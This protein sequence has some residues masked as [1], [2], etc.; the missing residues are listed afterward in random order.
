MN[1]RGAV[2]GIPELIK[3][4]LKPIAYHERP[5]AIDLRQTHISYLIFTPEFVYKI[6]KPVNFGFLDYTTLERRLFLC[7]EEVRLNR[8]LSPN[9][10]LDVIGITEED[11]RFLMGGQGEPVEYAVKMRRLDERRMLSS[12]L[13]KNEASPDIIKRIAHVI[14]AFHRSAET[15]AHISGFGSIDVIRNN[16]AENFDQT[17]PFIGKA[18]SAGLYASIK[19]FTDDFLLQNHALLNSR[20]KNNFIRDCH[21][22]IH[23]EHIF[24]ENGIE[25]IDC[26]EFNQRFR[27]SDVIA[28]TAFLSMDL[29]YSNWHGLSATLDS[30][31]FAET[32][33]YSGARLMDFYR[34]YRAY[35]RGKVECFKAFEP[36]VDEK[37]KDDSF[38][39]A[40][41]HFHLSGLYAAGGFRPMMVVVCGPSGTG[42]STLAFELS[43]HTGFVHLSSDRIRKELAGLPSGQRRTEPFGA[44][45]YSDEFTARTYDELIKRAAGLLKEGRSVVLDATFGRRTHLIEAKKAAQRTLALF[46]VVEC[47]ALNSTIRERLSKR[48]ATPEG[49]V[50]DADWE[51][52]LKQKA[53]FEEIKEPHAELR[54]EE[55]FSAGL[56][57]VVSAIF[58]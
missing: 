30:A 32:G 26:I 41:V 7:N 56:K 10:Y 11:G 4:V 29:D 31:Y 12:L 44:G 33:D 16:T 46:R 9:A 21:G 14:S 6:K 58:G 47:T 45:I 38:I 8:R 1:R 15:S 28:D 40:A 36:E 48:G 17:V 18:I 37:E 39:K 25:I 5:S 54:A 35:V 27:Y 57:R 34:C 23:S 3:G 20:I 49:V 51:I 19:E 52:F 42:K 24:I 2:D 55:P 53:I 43:R 22:D 13:E 50:S